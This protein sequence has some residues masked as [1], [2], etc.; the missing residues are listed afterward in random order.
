MKNERNREARRISAPVMRIDR[1]APELT[2]CI[3][4]CP[5]ARSRRWAASPNAALTSYALT[6][7]LRARKNARFAVFARDLVQTSCN[8]S[9]RQAVDF[10]Y[11]RS[12]RA[13]GHATRD[14]DRFARL[15]KPI[16]DHA[17][18]GNLDERFDVAV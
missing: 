2:S 4:T 14:R 7:A 18:L 11:V 3:A 5:R 6:S 12:A 15:R 8:D 17:L 1:H 10:E 9:V 13:N 16:G